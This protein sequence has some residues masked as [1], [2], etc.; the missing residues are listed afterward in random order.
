MS[1]Q[2]VTRYLQAWHISMAF[3]KWGVTVL[4]P[5]SI[6]SIPMGGLLHGVCGSQTKH[7]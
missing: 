4:F 2:L 3:K 6:A 1:I 5:L 7:F